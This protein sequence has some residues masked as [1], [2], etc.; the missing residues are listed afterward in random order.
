MGLSDL[1]PD[2]TIGASRVHAAKEVEIR[3]RVYKRTELIAVGYSAREI[4]HRI[5][6]LPHPEISELD[7]SI[8]SEGS[9]TDELLILPR[10]DDAHS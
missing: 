6:I 5:K 3:K 9:D 2:A 10:L 1:R 7:N 4:S 8:L